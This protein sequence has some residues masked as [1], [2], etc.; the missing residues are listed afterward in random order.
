MDAS[1]ASRPVGGARGPSGRRA[2]VVLLWASICVL[3]VGLSCPSKKEAALPRAPQEEGEFAIFITGNELSSLRPC[4]CS[5]GQLGG[6]EKRPAIFDRVPVSN[7]L[8]VE[9]GALVES[10][11]EQDLIKFRILF[12][13]LKLLGYDVVHLTDQDLEI[14]SNLG[15]STDSQ[16]GFDAIE[17]GEEGRSR[18]FTERFTVRGRDFIV[19]IAAWDPN[20]APVQSA[21]ELFEQTGGIPAVD[22]LL[23]G[24]CDSGLLETLVSDVPGIDGVICPSDSDEPRLLSDPGAR[25]LVF[26]VGRFG[27]YVCRLDIAVPQQAAEPVVRFEAIPVAEGLPDDP[28]LVQLYRQYQQ[29][30]RDSRLLEE[31][32]RIP[33]AEGLTF[34]GSTACKRCHEYEYD[35]WSTKAHA[36]A[37][38]SLKAVGSDYDPECVICHVVGM[39][40][41][42]GF[43]T[44]DKTPHLKDVGCETCHGPGSKHASTSGQTATTQ[45]QMACLDCHT[46]EKSTGY[47]GHE[48]EYMQKIVHWREPAVAGNVEH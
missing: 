20:V 22:I 34:T 2:S 15:L 39:E 9:T 28:A 45:P 1:D 11:R 27:R 14:A 43:I 23:L 35:K 30:V 44:E 26:T 17:V 5:G 31:Y 29:L 21:A 19:N 33:V 12:E 38:A 25:P 42:S 16:R 7:R 24:R 8:V 48:A 3:A 40:Y 37:F 13:A 18:V 47:A 41:E 10:D 46:P 4:G 36:N 6:L 32:P